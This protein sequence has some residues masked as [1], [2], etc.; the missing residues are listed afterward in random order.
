L[1]GEKEDD[2]DAGRGETAK[3]RQQAPKSNPPQVL[4]VPNPFD[5]V[6]TETSVPVNPFDQ[7][8]PANP[9]DR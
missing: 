8:I 1:L 4:S 5:A 9:F 6:R 3:P 2:E 7:K